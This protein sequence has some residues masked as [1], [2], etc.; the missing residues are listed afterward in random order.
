MADLPLIASPPT[1]WP[2]TWVEPC[3]RCNA[4]G[5]HDGKFTCWT[6]NGA[7]QK[8]YLTS[9]EARA[10]ARAAHHKKKRRLAAEAQS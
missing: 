7:G 2:Q 3:Y 8:T 5:R 6:C 4:K 9:P 1:G 10:A